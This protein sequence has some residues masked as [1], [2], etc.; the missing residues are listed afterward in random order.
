[1]QCKKCNVLLEFCQNLRPDRMG[2]YQERLRSEGSQTFQDYFIIYTFG[3]G[4]VGDNKQERP[5]Y[6]PAV[7]CLQYLCQ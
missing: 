2:P 4:W 1:M 3:V 6:M 7:G 5:P